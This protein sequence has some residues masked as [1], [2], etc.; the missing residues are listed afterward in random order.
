MASV[1]QKIGI[2]SYLVLVPGHCFLA[3]DPIEHSAGLPIGLETTMLGNDT[4][5]EV[6]NLDLLPA[7]TFLKEDEDSK[8]TFV[9]AIEAGNQQLQDCARMLQSGENPQFGLISIGDSRKKG[10]M[11][12]P[13]TMDK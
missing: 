12:I 4:I 6:A 7:A 8:K 10:I 3:F 5:T 1:L 2:Q 9:A 13:F 11:P